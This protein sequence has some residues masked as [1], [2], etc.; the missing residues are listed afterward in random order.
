GCEVP[1]MN[2]DVHHIVAW[3]Y[4]GVTDLKNLTLRCR[5]HHGD[6]NDARDFRNN[7]AHPDRVSPTKRA[8]PQYPHKEELRFNDSVAAS[9]SAH[10]K[11][12]TQHQ[13][14][15]SSPPRTPSRKSTQRDRDDGDNQSSLF[16]PA[17]TKPLTTNMTPCFGI[18]LTAARLC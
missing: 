2:C 14:P 9:Q 10:H 11:L 15:G 6:N 4:Q 17:Q 13:P 5:R 1:A 16:T 12:K 3:S 18:M 8:G 7:M